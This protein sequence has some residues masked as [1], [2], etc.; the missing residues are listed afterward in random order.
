MAVGIRLAILFA[1]PS[2]WQQCGAMGLLASSN[3]RPDSP[4]ALRCRQVVRADE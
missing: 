4:I 3:E 2:L 1:A